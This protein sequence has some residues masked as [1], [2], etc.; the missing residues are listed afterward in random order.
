M[1]KTAQVASAIHGSGLYHQR[2]RKALPLL[3]RQAEAGEQIFYGDLA[4]EL[5]ISNPRVLNYPLGAIGTR[6]NSCP[7]PG[8]RK[9]RRSSA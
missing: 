5:G 6:W 4:C 1:A 8:V 7:R 3:V 2:A 9:F